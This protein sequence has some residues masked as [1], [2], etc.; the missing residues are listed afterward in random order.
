MLNAKKF[1]LAGGILWGACMF[2]VTLVSLFTGYGRVF[3]M[4]MS[5]IYPGY[6]ISLLGSIVG[7]IYGFLDA[8]I[9]LFLLA[10]LYNKCL[11]KKKSS[12]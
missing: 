2:I 8:F 4:V 11:M 10:W 6:D 7:L 1:G 3:L 5:S 12:E 9:G